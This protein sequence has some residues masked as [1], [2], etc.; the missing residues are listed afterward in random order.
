M[1]ASDPTPPGEPNTAAGSN[2]QKPK[3]PAWSGNWDIPKVINLP[4]LR[5]KVRVGIPVR[6][7]LHGSFSYDSEGGA[8]IILNAN[9]P[10]EVQRYTLCHELQH[11]L[12]E[13]VDQMLEQFPEH[14]RPASWEWVGEG[15]P[16]P[17][18]APVTA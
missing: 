17:C 8:R 4:G 15:A 18:P 9:D 1:A 14:V 2:P 3:K 12:V 5:I 7:E 11:A 6:D 16:E 13:L 10:I